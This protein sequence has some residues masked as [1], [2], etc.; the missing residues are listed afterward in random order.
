MRVDIPNSL[1]S[2][3]EIDIKKSTASLPDMIKKNLVSIVERTVGRSEKVYS[4]RGRSV[5][6]DDM[7]HIWN[8]IDNRGTFQYRINRDLALYQK[9]ENCLEDNDKHYL[10]SFITAL[11]ED[12]PYG[13]VYYRMSREQVNPQ[14][15]SLESDRAYEIGMDMISSMREIP[16]SDIPAFLQQLDRM[17]LF[18][19]HPDVVKRLREEYTE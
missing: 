5:K 2:I 4:Y 6:D 14:E 10:E 11:E 7:P 19:H 3:W 9:L 15:S 1:D 17:D 16:G 12:F 18:L 13:D 8:T